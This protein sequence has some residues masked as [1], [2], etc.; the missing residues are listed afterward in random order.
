MKERRLKSFR[1]LILW[2]RPFVILS[3]CFVWPL[4]VFGLQGIF[5][6]WGEVLGGDLMKQSLFALEKSCQPNRQAAF[7]FFLQSLRVNDGGKTFRV[8]GSGKRLEV[9][10]GASRDGA[11]K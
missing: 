5:L 9:V 11:L 4:N 8:K 2:L 10:R 7:R 6:H 3:P 1:F